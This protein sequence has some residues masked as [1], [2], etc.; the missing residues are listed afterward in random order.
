MN[1]KEK[2]SSFNEKSEI[3]K[4]LSDEVSKLPANEELTKE[5]LSMLNNKHTK[6]VLDEDI[7]NSYY[8]YLN[9][10]IYLSNREKVQNNSSR[11]VLT[12]HEVRHSIQS[13]VLQ[14]LNFILSNIELIA[15]IISIILFFFKKF[16]MINI[17]VYLGIVIVSIIPRMILEFDAVINSIKITKKYLKQKMSKDKLDEIISI[18]K[19]KIN[20]L[21]PLFIFNLIYGKIIR[22]II[23]TIAYY[24]FI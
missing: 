9:D 14:I 11:V 17:L 1:L 3:S 5:I 2:F 16:S 6:I 24:F 10:T 7:K 8:V 12:A 19:F 21:M 4:K 18:Y 23:L 20:I 13:K 15:F 22:M